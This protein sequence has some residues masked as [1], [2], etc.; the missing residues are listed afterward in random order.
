MS[1]SSAEPA[2]PGE[3]IC[4]RFSVNLAEAA[5]L[6]L[7]LIVPLVM[8][9][10]A[11]RTFEAA[12]LAAAAP[13]A[14]I[15]LFALIAAA[16]EGRA[17]VPLGVRR[18][19]AFWAFLALMAS[20]VMATALSETPWI[21]FFGDYFRREGLV[22][23]LIYA[24]VFVSILALMKQRDQLE[25][26]ID[27]LLLASVIPCI[28][29]LQQRY[30]YDF[31]FTAGLG[32]GTVEARPGSNLGN[33]IFLSAYLLLIIPLTIARLVNTTGS[34]SARSLW[35]I[36]LGLQ[37]FAAILTQSR[38]PLLGIIATLF[39]LAI[40]LGKQLRLRGLI[41]TAFGIGALMIAG[42][43]LINFAPDLQSL[44]KNTPLQRFIFTSGQDFTSN[45]R[46]GIWQSGV[47]AFL[48]LPLWRQLLG[49]GPDAAHFNYF[50]Y[51]PS[52]LMRI[53]GLTY[54]IDRLHNE[55]ME[56]MMTFGLVGLTAQL[57]LMSALVWLAVKRIA[58]LQGRM[59]LIV[60]VT[61]CV[62]AGL[63]TGFGVMSIGGSRGL[64]PIGCGLG[65]A[66]AWSMAVLGGS[67]MAFGP[68]NRLESRA[69]GV[70]LV[71][72]ACAL[73][74]SWIEAQ[75]GVSTIST[76]L[77]TAAYAA[78]ILLTG[79]NAFGPALATDPV[80]DDA[81]N[82][83]PIGGLAK[84]L[85]LRA[86]IVTGLITA[87]ALIV[88]TAAYFPPLVSTIVSPPSLGRLHL[89]IVPLLG[90]I[91]SG[92]VCSWNEARR[93]ESS[94]RIGWTRDF[95]W[96]SAP[97]LIFA[98][99]YLLVGSTIAE[100]QNEQ[101][102][103]RINTLLMFAF[104][105]YPIAVLAIGLALYLTASPR[106]S[107]RESNS[108]A[109]ATLG[110]AILAGGTT[111]W[112]AMRDVRADTFIKLAG[113]AS[114]QNRQDVATTFFGMAADVMPQERR[115]TTSYA[116]I[117]YQRA[118]YELGL[119]EANPSLGPQILEHLAKAEALIAPALHIAPRDPWVTLAYANARRL[120]GISRLENYQS[121]EIRANHI[122]IARAY[123]DLARAQFPAYPWS[124][125]D[126][127]Q[128]EIDL[129][130]YA[131]AYKKFDEME[132]LYPDNIGLYTERLRFTFAH[133][134]HANAIGA[135][136]R[137]IAA[138]SAG[139]SNE[140]DLK[141]VLANYYYQ[142]RQPQQALDVWVDILRAQPDNFSVF[143][144][145]VETYAQM[146]RRELA[147]SN[148]QSAL[149]RLAAMPRTGQTDAAK[150]RLEALIAHLV[151]PSSSR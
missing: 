101:A 123:F 30:G 100:A 99:I 89:I 75:V 29:A 21:A 69:D 31:F 83:P 39:L 67:W 47:D 118:E 133:G 10:S 45:S 6:G 116:G 53:E 34:W 46:I 103:E 33:S 110:L 150:A 121:K 147:L 131:M 107:A 145:I 81:V 148:A 63:G 17:S 28:Y 77:L 11:A 27:T 55:S 76:R 42:L 134:D 72:L 24:T 82:V 65:V 104:G 96:I 94:S 61:G 124:L 20:A 64:F 151:P 122:K 9:V 102:G 32:G 36:L 66:L 108:W 8:N 93:A 129:G 115:F 139:S 5:W 54:M 50:P 91:I 23:W 52:W 48:H 126:W 143:S 127:A 138:Q 70:L 92:F 51:L 16:I 105:A 37:L 114:A 142:I 58:Q 40:A 132:N 85:P 62:L 135:L 117:L 111:Y 141:L 49:A 128:M 57:I 2:A 149:T 97:W 137:G 18:Q 44:V 140:I 79:T 71:A 43:L 112:A 146:G 3:S 1:T 56:T 98:F 41:Y 35:L 78:L 87:L 59:P 88:A 7:V 26:L 106:L 14:A 74:G 119:L 12:K 125:R 68:G 15:L 90:M 22:S 13:L 136:R 130:N 113:W 73:I 86:P 95:F 80:S 25:R 84:P 144:N 4:G 60:Y 109:L 38:G 19:T 120:Q